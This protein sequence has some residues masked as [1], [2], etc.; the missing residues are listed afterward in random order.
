[1]AE[2][3]L[4]LKYTSFVK[5]PL[6]PGDACLPEEGIIVDGSNR[7]VTQVLFLEVGDF[8]LDAL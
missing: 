8:T 6:G 1:M 7:N 5:A 2:C 3:N 4:D